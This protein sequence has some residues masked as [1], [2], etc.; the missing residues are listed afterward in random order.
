MTTQRWISLLGILASSALLALLA[1]AMARPSAGS[2]SP[3]VNAQG[4]FS[5]TAPRPAPDVSLR[6]FDEAGTTW[7]L[8]DQRGKTVVINFWASWCQPCRAEAGVLA[9]A[10]RDYATRN[11]VLVGMNVWDNDSSARAFLDEFGIA[12]P[13]GTDES[14]RA[15]VSYGV[16]GIPE[17]FVVNP[18]GEIVGR[19]IGPITRS[20]LDEMVAP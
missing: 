4:S 7:R 3:G 16:V 9:Q 12:Y 14:K 17:T 18:R 13:N 2:G 15:A 11:I 10:A 5:R 1:W 19:W 6:L 20:T 8:S